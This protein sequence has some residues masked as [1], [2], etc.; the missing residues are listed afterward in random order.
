M[1]IAYNADLFKEANLETPSELFAKG[2]WT[3]EK[4]AEVAKVIT[5]TGEG[6]IGYVHIDEI[7]TN[8]W[9][10][11]VPIMQAYGGGSWDQ[12]EPNA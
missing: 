6:N 5:E 3:W 10:L 4:F 1:F 12:L 2:K 7:S 11:L 9:R 8:P